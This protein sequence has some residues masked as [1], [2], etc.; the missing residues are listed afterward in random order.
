MDPFSLTVGI[1]SLVALTAQTLNLT[2]KYFHGVKN[3][4]KSAAELSAQLHFLRSI[5]SRLD[6]LLRGDDAKGQSFNDD[7]VLVSSV[8]A[9]KTRL[10]ML[11]GK[12]NAVGESLMGRLK[13]P[14]NEKEH[15]ESIQELKTLSTWIQFAITID[16]R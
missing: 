10:H 4:S 12:L 7:S 9:C 5:L 15:Q 13:W 6:E 16:G 11:H 1:T 14:L 3:A 8:S 2:K